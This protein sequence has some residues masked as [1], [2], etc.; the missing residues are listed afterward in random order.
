MPIA[1]TFR[2]SN[3]VNFL[4]HIVLERLS[5]EATLPDHVQ[6]AIGTLTPAPGACP[7]AKKFV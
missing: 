3:L 2:T 5:C 1:R 6:H 7:G 4:R